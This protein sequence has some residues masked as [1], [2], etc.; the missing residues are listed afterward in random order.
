[1]IRPCC[2][3]SLVDVFKTRMTRLA[4]SRSGRLESLNISSYFRSTL[5]FHPP[6]LQGNCAAGML[7]LGKLPAHE[8]LFHLLMPS[9]FTIDNVRKHGM[10]HH[11]EVNGAP[12]RK[13]VCLDVR[14]KRI[15]SRAVEPARLAAPAVKNN[16]AVLRFLSRR[17]FVGW[18]SQ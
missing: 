9:V 5:V 1:M 17:R 13:E 4:T 7:I 8:S 10:A 16:L 12:Q 18:M 11:D 15:V 3:S 6:A 14:V 2:D